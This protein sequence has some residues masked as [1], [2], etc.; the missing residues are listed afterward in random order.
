MFSLSPTPSP[1]R[2]SLILPEARLSEA[3][4]GEEMRRAEKQELRRLTTALCPPFLPSSSDVAKGE[5]ERRGR[6]KGRKE[7]VESDS[8]GASLLETCAEGGREGGREGK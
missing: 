2:V 5:I 3:V 6:K 8:D 7:G 1:G 4:P